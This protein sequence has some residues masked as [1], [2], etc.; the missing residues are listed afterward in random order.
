MG[1]WQSSRQNSRKYP[2][3]GVMA[4]GP[5]RAPGFG[6]ASR[7]GLCPFLTT[8]NGV[9]SSRCRKSLRA[10]PLGPLRGV[11]HI[12]SS[13]AYTGGRFCRGGKNNKAVARKTAANRGANHSRGAT[14]P[15]GA[16][17]PCR[18]VFKSHGTRRH[19]RTLPGRAAGPGRG[20]RTLPRRLH[21]PA[22]SR[23]TRLPW[24]WAYPR[25]SRGHPA[26]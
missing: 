5:S 17:T 12:V 3:P 19:G 11:T 23:R 7:C 16:P 8:G 15:G 21:W 20:S 14:A 24:C 18:M 13:G 25:A 4:W 1:W 10:K 22:P 26:R 9:P 2:V 6:G